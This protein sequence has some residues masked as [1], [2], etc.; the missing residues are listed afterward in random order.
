MAKALQDGREY[1]EQEIVIERPDGSRWVALAH[2][3]PLRDESGQIT[4]AVNVL[5]DITARKQAEEELR[6]SDRR[7]SEFL[8]MLAHELR[9]PLAP[10]RNGLQIL[11]LSGDSSATSTE[12]R[13]MMERQLGQLVRLIDDLLDLSRITNGKIELR[14]ERVDLASVVRDAVET[15]RP[16]LESSR[17]ELTLTQPPGA[18]FVYVDRARLAQ[19]FANLLNNSA[20][21]T[22][23]GG[24]IWLTVQRH[25][26]DAVVK[27]RDTGVGIAPDML[28]RIFDLFT[29]GDG[30]LERS[31]G[32]LG[33]GLS[34]VRHLVEMHGGRVEAR[35]DGP[36]KGSEFVVRLPV[37]LS[38][39]PEPSRPRVDEDAGG[40]RYRI[41]VVDDN[42][43]AAIS[44]ALLLKMMG[45]ETQTAYDGLE[46]VAVAEGFR[47]EVVL[48]DIGLPLLNGHD[49]CRSI[50]KQPWS[51]GM[52][53][54]ALTGWGQEEDRRRSKEAGFNFHLVK[55]VDHT[56][57]ER[58]LSGLVLPLR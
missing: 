37:M 14:R 45:H 26:S 6:S 38:P 32:G 35:S 1:N 7:K 28:A 9:N 55:P 18:V 16:V 23:P 24:R 34:L 36:G 4:G 21:Y 19:V 58:L 30:S 29:Q 48:L 39:E 20:K 46:A 10:L 44:L 50:R 8:A 11:H 2:A 56:D 33:I 5:L 49:A 31:Q 25:G 40:L 22:E 57:I 17:H 52:T 27:V 54:I 41:L 3:N 42:K 15:S 12:A 47:P 53:F 51:N 13:A 43:D